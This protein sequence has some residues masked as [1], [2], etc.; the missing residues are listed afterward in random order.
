LTSL[1]K[2]VYNN[3][4]II[5]FSI[6]RSLKTVVLLSRKGGSGKSTIATH[7]AVCADLDGKAAALLDIDPQGSATKW[8]KR[9]QADTPTVYPA[10]PVQ[11]PN[12]LSKAKKQS[13]DL[14]IIDTAGYADAQANAALQLADLVL[15]PCRASVADLDAIDYTIEQ[16][17]H[18]SR[19]S[20]AAVVLNAAPVRG[21]IVTD[22]RE[23][24]EKRVTVAPVVLCQRAAYANAWIDGRAVQE[25]EPHGKAAAEIEQLYQWIL[26]DKQ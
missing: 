17:R 3:T 9:R 2:S 4:G 5:L 23:A 1:A 21:K 26:R 7:L 13:A 15:I 8:S 11:V 18:L 16:A 25:Y 10:T 24:L 6:G 20:R 12:L 19:R 22:V 14:I